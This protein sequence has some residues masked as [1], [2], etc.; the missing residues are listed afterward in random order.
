MGGTK[1]PSINRPGNLILL[2]GDGVRGCHGWVETHR[3][4]AHDNGWS[5]P[6]WQ[7]SE[8]F[9]VTYWDGTYYINNKGDR[10]CS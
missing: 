6:W 7:T 2:C 8:D 3:E 4:E 10:I 5:L 9:P 1:D